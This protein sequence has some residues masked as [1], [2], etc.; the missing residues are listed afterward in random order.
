MPMLMYEGEKSDACRFRL[1]PRPFGQPRLCAP[2]RRRPASRR[3]D[4]KPD[5]AGAEH[6]DEDGNVDLHVSA[7]V[8]SNNNEGGELL[9]VET[10]AEWD[11]IEEVINTFLADEEAEGEE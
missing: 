6:E 10:D 5:P 2:V 8:P 3:D 4:E 7:Y 9:P 11:M 1:P